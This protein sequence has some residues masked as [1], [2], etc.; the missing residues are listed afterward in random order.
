MRD[1]LLFVVF[2]YLAVLAFL[3]C[4]VAR[5]MV[6]HRR[7]LGDDGAPSP[8]G[9]RFA[10]VVWRSAVVLVA[11]GHLLAFAL[12][13]YL[14]LWNRQLWRLAFIEVFGV[15]AGTVAAAGIFVAL[16]RAIRGARSDASRSSVNVVADTLL[17]IAMLSGVAVAVIYRW[18]SSWSEVTIVPYLR[19][20]AQLAPAPSL[21]TQLPPLVKLHIVCA[22]AILAILPFTDVARLV[23]TRVDRVTHRMFEAV[24]TAV[25]SPASTVA[26]RIAVPVRALCARVL[27]NPAEDN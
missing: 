15:V 13:D 19:S 1:H 23:A 24:A 21:V 10:G 11:L 9:S 6:R 26:V 2:P 14:L 7:P 12:P 22:L 27:R 16:V 18:A 5:S 17:L 20:L 25:P 3:P 4:C 8:A